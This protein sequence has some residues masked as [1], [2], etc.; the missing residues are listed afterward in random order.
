V[1]T[2]PHPNDYESIPVAIVTAL[3]AGR[4]VAGFVGGAFSTLGGFF[5][6]V[7]AESYDRIDAGQFV[8]FSIPVIFGLLSIVFSGFAYSRVKAGQWMR[9]LVV[10]G[11]L[12]TVLLSFVGAML[13]YSAFQM[14]IS[15][16]RQP[17][18]LLFGLGSMAASVGLLL[19]VEDVDRALTGRRRFRSRQ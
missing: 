12:G 3:S 19:G 16:G 4:V 7:A 1:P 8:M 6:L 5:C 9:P 13:I 14:P 2:Q 10:L 11:Y 15:D 18:I 17:L